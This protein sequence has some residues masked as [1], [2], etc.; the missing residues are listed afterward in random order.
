[1][2]SVHDSFQI[3]FADFLPPPHLPC[4]II[5][6]DRVWD[7]NLKPE[8]LLW[9]VTH[10]RDPRKCEKDCV[11]SSRRD[12]DVHLDIRRMAIAPICPPEDDCRFCKIHQKLLDA[13]PPLTGADADIDTAIDI[14]VQLYKSD[15]VYH[16]RFSSCDKTDEE[17]TPVDSEPNVDYW[18]KKI[19]DFT[20]TH[21]VFHPPGD[22]PPSQ[23]HDLPKEANGSLRAKW[24]DE[25][26]FALPDRRTLQ[27]GDVSFA[28]KDV[29]TDIARGFATPSDLEPNMDMFVVRAVDKRP[30]AVVDPE[31]LNVLSMLPTTVKYPSPLDALKDGRWRYAAKIDIDKGFRHVTLS[32]DLADKSVLNLNGRALRMNR[33]PFGVEFGPR[34]FCSLLNTHLEDF[35]FKDHLI[36]YVDDILI[37][38]ESPEEVA[39]IAYHLVS[40]LTD[41][42]I[43]VSLSKMFLRPCSSL[44]FL[45]VVIDLRSK[46]A[47]V[48]K[49]LIDR[50]RMAAT[51]LSNFRNG[52]LC[53]HQVKLIQELTGRIQF[54]VKIDR[55]LSLVRQ[56]LDYAA[57]S[58]WYTNRARESVEVLD[59]QRLD[60][61]RTVIPFGSAEH[62]LIVSDASATTGAAIIVRPGVPH[63]IRTTDLLH[64]ACQVHLE[65]RKWSSTAAEMYTSL[66]AM[67]YALD[68]KDLHDGTRINLTVLTDSRVSADVHHSEAAPASHPLRTVLQQ[69]YSL[70]DQY[71]DA[72]FVQFKW[73]S[74]DTRWARFADALSEI[75]QY[76]L[77]RLGQRFR[78]AVTS[79]VQPIDIVAGVAPSAAPAAI[80]PS[81]HRLRQVSSSPREMMMREFV[82]GEGASTS[83]GFL[84]CLEWRPE[85]FPTQHIAFPLW[86]GTTHADLYHDMRA[87]ISWF[88]M[89]NASTRTLT[90]FVQSAPDFHPSALTHLGKIAATADWSAGSPIKTPAPI[91]ESDQGHLVRVKG[92]ILT[93]VKGPDLPLATG[94]PPHFDLGAWLD[95]IAGEAKT[96]GP[97][98]LITS[99]PEFAL[100]REPE[101]VDPLSSE[102]G[103]PG[104]DSPRQLSP[105]SLRQLRLAWEK[106]LPRDEDLSELPEPLPPSS[107]QSTA[108][109]SGPISDMV[110]IVQAEPRRG[111]VCDPP[112]TPCSPP[113]VELRDSGS[114]RA[115]STP[116]NSDVSSPE[117]WMDEP[118][119]CRGAG[120]TRVITGRETAYICD[121]QPCPDWAVCFRCVPPPLSNGED[122]PLMCPKHQREDYLSRLLAISSDTAP[123]TIARLFDVLLRLANGDPCITPILSDEPFLIPEVEQERRQL[124]FLPAHRRDVV[125]RTIRQVRQLAAT[126]PNDP[127]ARDLQSLPEVMA[128]Y[129][130][131]RLAR[132][133]FAG[134][135]KISPASLASDM[136]TF[137]AACTALRVVVPPKCGAGDYLSAA[138]SGVKKPHSDKYPFTPC[139]VRRGLAERGRATPQW[140]RR[141]LILHSLMGCRPGLLPLLTWSHFRPLVSR[142]LGS[143]LLVLMSF[144]HKDAKESKRSGGPSRPYRT[145][146]PAEELEWLATGLKEGLTG[147]IWP[148]WDAK[149]YNKQVKIT[150]TAAGI[151]SEDL[152]PFSDGV[153]PHSLRLGLDLALLQFLKPDTVNAHMNW[154]QGAEMHDLYGAKDVA[155]LVT[156]IR[157]ATK[158]DVCTPAPGWFIRTSTLEL[159]EA[160]VLPEME[161]ALS[162]SFPSSVPK[163]QLDSTPDEPVKYYDLEKVVMPRGWKPFQMKLPSVIKRTVRRPTLSVRTTSDFGS[164]GS[165]AASA[166]QVLASPPLL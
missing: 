65:G 149:E 24:W 50:T 88:G 86:R 34:A 127:L 51:R 156:A 91:A 74:R 13:A 77:L 47:K 140:A 44:T 165:G 29:F 7:T 136:S 115:L 81:I 56:H 154:A 5:T 128:W 163:I 158:L 135:R 38:A 120:C 103:T 100:P 71:S 121:R 20:R 10:K 92:A 18:L 162:P 80:V 138:G 48:S 11:Y 108:W 113:P 79:R 129:V 73:Q 105:A 75:H 166:E 39:E 16:Q 8:G 22:A 95:A 126:L 1:M 36:V 35:E 31:I 19:D 111:E 27:P 148:N 37:L 114:H 55:T 32:D 58:F 96:P 141:A 28:L 109:H 52:L 43:Q 147:P 33:L 145:A 3:C 54:S 99:R 78:S 23:N 139:A 112:Q 76:E 63:V 106:Y 137:A 143:I 89:D 94:W 150:A 62:W 59:L 122:F 9:I 160:P 6:P 119:R 101:D 164:P 130:I 144:S 90:I 85:A 133:T 83:M 41:R 125:K 142:Q 97:G 118:Q 124:A 98:A 49:K 117:A 123:S 21:L 82:N 14:A 57:T 84:G 61:W 131:E 26:S 40:F 134:W 30:R 64:E 146:L 104:P 157:A 17:S 15:W 4:L 93:F 45:G 69:I 107:R 151:T 66:D 2:C 46:K 102:S 72:V 159:A 132:R 12:N 42:R 161:L 152:I 155:A 53:R 68:E 70:Q 25:L 87:L 60:L 153:V 116:E 110:Q 67:R